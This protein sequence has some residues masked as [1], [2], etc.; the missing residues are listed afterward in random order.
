[1]TWLNQ[2]LLKKQVI[3]GA[4]WNFWISAGKTC[5]KKQNKGNSSWTVPWSRWKGKWSSKEITQEKCLFTWNTELNEV[6]LNQ[7]HNADPPEFGGSFD[8]AISSHSW[9]LLYCWIKISAFGLHIFKGW[10]SCIAILFR[11]K[12]DLRVARLACFQDFHGICFCFCQ[13]DWIELV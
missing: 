9:S 13:L 11:E 4:S 6:G 1:M 7:N 5:W 12:I 10:N 8:A 3:Y 2:V